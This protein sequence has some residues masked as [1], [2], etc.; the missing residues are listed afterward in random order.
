MSADVKTAMLSMPFPPEIIL[1][2]KKKY[3]RCFYNVLAL[4]TVIYS[5][6]KENGGIQNEKKDHSDRQGKMQW[7]R[8]MC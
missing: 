6:Y 2:S 5:W 3:I 4:H 1:L 7:L 8:H